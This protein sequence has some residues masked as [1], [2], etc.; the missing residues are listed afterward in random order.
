MANLREGVTRRV[1]APRR[2]A[3]KLHAWRARRKSALAAL[4]E[5]VRDQPNVANRLPLLYVRSPR[6]NTHADK[7]PYASTPAPMANAVPTLGDRIS[8]AGR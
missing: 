7:A 2:G 4:Q 6:S 3:E 1:V 8:A 5:P